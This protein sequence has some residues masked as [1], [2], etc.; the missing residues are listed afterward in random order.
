MKFNKNAESVAEGLV[1]SLEDLEKIN[2][3]TQREFTQDELYTFKVA[4][5]DNEVDRDFERFDNNAL[6]Q[7]QKLFLGTTGIF[8]HSSKAANQQARIYETFVTEKEGEVQS[9]GEPYRVLE[10]K[11]YMVKTA[12]NRDLI[13]EIEGG[14]KKE[15]SVGCSMASATCSICGKDRKKEDCN[16]IPG[17]S[18]N[19]ELCHTVLSDAIDA[20]EWSFVAVPAQ[21]RAGV[22]KG[23]YNEN[24]NSINQCVDN[25]YKMLESGREMRLSSREALYLADTLQQLRADCGDYRRQVRKQVINTAASTGIPDSETAELFYQALDR[26]SIPEM[27]ALGKL[28]ENTSRND[29]FCTEKQLEPVQICGNMQNKPS[30]KSFLI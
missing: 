16:H 13:L 3:L 14:I 8:D 27:K 23:F 22:T 19:G 30:D 5:C 17:K 2:R 24:T 15:V 28:L 12:G 11:V 4:L 25:V 18:Y 10:A 29:V 7:L 20:Y 26:L 21:K 9:L 6:D 1:T